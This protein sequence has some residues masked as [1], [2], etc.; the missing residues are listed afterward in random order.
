[1]KGPAFGTKLG[2][3]VDPVHFSDLTRFEHALLVEIYLEADRISWRRR[4]RQFAGVG[5][6]ECD[7]IA[8]ACWA[9]A[10]FE[11]AA[12]TECDAAL[13]DLKRGDADTVAEVRW[14]RRRRR[15]TRGAAA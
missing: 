9:R 11:E 12:R 1:M 15:S 5:T 7:E 6:P 8:R 4:A 10:R 3:P 13:E 2:S 14:R